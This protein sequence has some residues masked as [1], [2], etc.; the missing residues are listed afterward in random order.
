MKSWVM[1]PEVRFQQNATN[2]H[3]ITVYSTPT[4]RPNSLSVLSAGVSLHKTL[5]AFLHHLGQP[6]SRL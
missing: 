1:R 3:I 2:S 6:P 5:P 4:S